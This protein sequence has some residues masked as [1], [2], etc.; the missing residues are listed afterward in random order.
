LI[1]SSV[2]CTKADNKRDRFFTEVEEAASLYSAALMCI[3][4]K[5][6]FKLLSKRFSE[7]N[8]A[9]AKKMIE[10]K[11]SNEEVSEFRKIMHIDNLVDEDMP[12]KELREFCFNVHPKWF[13]KVQTLR[14]PDLSKVLTEIYSGEHSQE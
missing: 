5:S 4:E 12:F 1:L 14:F 6:T 13:R 3:V 8:E 10:L 2:A 11:L 9:V 7:E